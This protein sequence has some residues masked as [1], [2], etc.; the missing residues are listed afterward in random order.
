[1][2]VSTFANFQTAVGAV[3]SKSG[4]TYTVSGVYTTLPNGATQGTILKN[5]AIFINFVYEAQT[6]QFIAANDS[7]VSGW[8]L[9]WVD[10]GGVQH[11]SDAQQFVN[12]L[13]AN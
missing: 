12:W 11:V 5:G 6:S 7:N 8:S 3:V 4:A 1:M 13:A 10:A 9:R 2:S